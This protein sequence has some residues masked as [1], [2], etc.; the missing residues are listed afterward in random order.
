MMPS[1]LGT[2]KAGKGFGPRSDS[3]FL[4]PESPLPS[5]QGPKVPEQDKGPKV[6]R[7]LPAGRPVNV[8]P[9]RRDFRSWR[10]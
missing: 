10:Y 3:A 4:S 6:R 5:E 8:H 9:N 2:S 1:F 7:R